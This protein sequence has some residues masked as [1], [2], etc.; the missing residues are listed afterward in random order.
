MSAFTIRKVETGGSKFFK[1]ADHAEHLILITK[2]NDVREIDDK[3]KGPGTP[4]AFI[5]FVDLDSPNKEVHRN[6][7]VTHG[8]IVNRLEAGWD[9]VLGIVGKVPTKRG[10][11]AWVLKSAPI[12]D[13]QRAIEWA[14]SQA[15]DENTPA[16]WDAVE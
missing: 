5:D 6:V 7:Q 12:E 1:P 15:P 4:A 14:K 16:P 8:G 10:Y 9:N 2:V 11:Q 3:F 13:E